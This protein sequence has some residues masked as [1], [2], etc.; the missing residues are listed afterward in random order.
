MTEGLEQAIE[1][2]AL[3]LKRATGDE[4]SVEQHSLPDMIATDKYLAT[5]AAVRLRRRGVRFVRLI[6]PGA[7]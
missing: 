7:C 1:E 5:K 2:S 3:G 4:G 6:P